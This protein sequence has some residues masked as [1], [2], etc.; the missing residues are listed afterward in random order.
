MTRIIIL[1]IVGMMIAVTCHAV[2][3]T[4]TVDDAKAQKV[5]NSFCK[6][7]RYQESITDPATNQQIPNPESKVAFTKRYIATYIKEVVKQVTAAEA[8]DQARENAL[9]SP[10]NAID[11]LTK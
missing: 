8:A 9:Q 11:I 3:F 5:V 4:F 6:A 1:T 7:Y 10:D 2:A